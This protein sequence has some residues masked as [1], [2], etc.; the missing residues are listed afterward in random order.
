MTACIGDSWYTVIKS[1]K[2]SNYGIVYGDH[3]YK[4]S[5]NG[6]KFAAEADAMKRA[7]FFAFLTY[8]DTKID[9]L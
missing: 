3:K 1:K 4:W 2:D 7:E 6:K 8:N 9:D 5:Y